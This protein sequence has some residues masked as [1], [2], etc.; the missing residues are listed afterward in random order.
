MKLLHIVATPKKE[1]SASLE[2]SNKLIKEFIKK[3]PTC[4]IKTLRLYDEEL[5]HLSVLSQASELERMKKIAT[6]FSDFD[7]Y[8]F[9]A[10]MWNLS[11]PS[12]LKTY[13]DHIVV[14]DIS[15]KYN[16][17]GI[18]LGLLKNKKAIC[19]FSRGGIY[20]FWPLSR[21]A[22]DKKYMKQILKF[23]GIK[24]TSFVEIDGLDMKP[25]NRQQIINK[26]IIKAVKVAKKL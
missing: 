8:I 20:S 9:S 11:I 10:P 4:E 19:V 21:L 5:P 16:K 1:N 17:Y 14:K 12:I 23:M 3:H 6:H 25:E 22:Y 7:Y 18:P 2:V 24:N 13:I 15:F 26:A